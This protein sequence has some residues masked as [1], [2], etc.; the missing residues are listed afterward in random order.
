MVFSFCHLFFK[1]YYIIFETHFFVNGT[2]RVLEKISSYKPTFL[3]TLIAFWKRA[4][5]IWTLFHIMKSS[6]FKRDKWHYIWR[7][8]FLNA[9]SAIKKRKLNLKENVYPEFV[10]CVLEK[11]FSHMFICTYLWRAL[12]RNMISELGIGLANL[13]FWIAA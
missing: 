11:G 12:F 1:K 4:L 8:L 10:D 6:F 5:H 7:A 3:M 9:I 13:I 2:Y